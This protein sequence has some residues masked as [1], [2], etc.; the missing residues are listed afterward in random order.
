MSERGRRTLSA[1][2]LARVEGE[3]LRVRAFHEKPA[4]PPSIPDKPQVALVNMGVYV[5][6]TES[7]MTALREDRKDERSRHDFGFL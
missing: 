4:E 6:E 7:L 2:V 5:F 3:D 1:K